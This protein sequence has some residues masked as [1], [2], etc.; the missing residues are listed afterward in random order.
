MKVHARDIINLDA[1]PALGTVV[2]TGPKAFRAYFPGISGE[3]PEVLEFEHRT[4]I[5]RDEL[6]VL[7][8]HTNHMEL[9]GSSIPENSEFFLDHNRAVFAVVRVFRVM[10]FNG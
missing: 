9:S 5:D 6:N 7:V 1:K 3:E 8:S 10:P 2:E 4:E